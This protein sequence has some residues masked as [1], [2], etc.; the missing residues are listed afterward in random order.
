MSSTATATAQ[1]Q[2][3]Q[4]AAG[5]W[6]N[7]VEIF[8]ARVQAS[9]P[10]VAMRYKENGVWR[11]LTWRDFDQA[12]REIA[13]GLRSLGVGLGDR[14]CLLANT[15]HEWF[16]ADVGILL[17]GAVTVPIYQSNLPDQCEYIVNDCQ[18]KV[19]I[20]EDPHQVEKLLAEKPKLGGLARV[21]YMQDVANL[22]KKDAK[23]RLV[24]KLDEV[25]PS[26]GDDRKWLLSLSELREQGRAW[27]GKNAGVL[28]K[29][30]Q[31]VT[32]DHIFTIV[33]TSGTTGPPKGVVLTHGNIVFECSA[34]EN[35]LSVTEEDEQLLFLPLAHIFAKILEWTAISRGARTAF[36]ESIAKLIDN[37]KETQP[38]FM[39]AVPRVYEKAYVKIQSNFAEKRK[40]PVAR[41]LIDWALDKG[42]ERSKIEQRGGRVS[43]ML[44]FQVNL[45]DKLVFSKIKATFGGR[46]R[47]FVSGGAPLAREIAE[48]FHAAGILILEGYGLTETTAATHVNRPDR[49]RF[50][51]VGHAIPGVEVKIAEDGEILMRGPNILREYY[52]KPEATREAID[53]D[54]WFHSGD[55]GTIEEGFLRIT[56]RKKD[57]IVT[58]GGKNVAPQNIEGALKASCP[59]VSQVMVHG[60][61]RHF[62]SALITLNEE[63]VTAFAK[64]KGISVAGDDLAKHHEVRALIQGAVDKLNKSLA[65]YETIK[66]FELLPRDFSQET[67]ELTPSLKV[68]RKF[69]TDKFKDVLDGFYAGNGA[70]G[71]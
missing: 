70:K 50:G 22:E 4:P 6:K 48:F 11:S 39:G 12:A 57:I 30:W 47:F 69:V 35:V 61:K 54:G 62:L 26:G 67:G 41:M 21:V 5:K 37:M 7:A 38:T 2:D 63:A 53:A 60:D 9:G 55:I 32:P 25:A 16:E 1:A 43:G 8:N 18:A 3:K 49:Y 58:A 56:D 46:L 52:G 59:Y 64:D 24:V 33:Y 71:D 66:K 68:K 15:R 14:V 65:S 42:R 40:K 13:G 27:L 29:A 28:E 31:D 36:A 34:M 51:T 44:G 17:A 10:R 19:I 45:A 20:A 23:G